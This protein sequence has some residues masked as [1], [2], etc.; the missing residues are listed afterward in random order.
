MHL[1]SFFLNLSLLIHARLAWAGAACFPACAVACCTWTTGPAAFA[2]A[3]GIG[4]D[5][6][7]C[8][9]VCMV[10]C[11]TAAWVP[12]AC[13][14]NDTTIAVITINGTST[15]KLISDVYVGDEILTLVGGQMATTRVVHNILSTGGFDFFDITV[16]TDR[17]LST[18]RVTPEH[19]I[20]LVN[21]N[22]ATKMAFPED[23]RLGDKMLSWD[24]ATA[25]VTHIKR[26]TGPEKYTLV[27]TEGTVIAS[28]LYVSTLCET[29]IRDDLDA[30][31]AL[32]DW[33]IR[34]PYHV[35]SPQPQ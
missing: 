1:N 27:T 34:H 17:R 14:A 30:D 4:I 31:V 25:V 18:L 7:G 2:G 21:N 29:E 22:E 19:G 28:S 12:P 16:R 23:V 8:A 24:G 35:H 20:L 11:A 6:T 9:G 15:E 32:G 5:Y 26:S 10:A 13:F 33:K 3:L